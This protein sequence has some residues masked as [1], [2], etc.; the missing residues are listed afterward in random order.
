MA[1]SLPKISQNVFWGPNFE[2]Y[3]HLVFDVVDE[4]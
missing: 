4:E 3:G 1:L 2:K